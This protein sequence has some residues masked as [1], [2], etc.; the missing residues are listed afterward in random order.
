MDPDLLEERG[1]GIDL[2]DESRVALSFGPSP[3]PPLGRLSRRLSG[4]RRTASDRT[5]LA[6]RERTRPHLTVPNR[7][8]GQ[9]SAP[10]VTRV[11]RT[12][13]PFRRASGRSTMVS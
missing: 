13:R 7:T 4:V 6:T 8:E 2:D 3:T 9:Q 10:K 5:T 1:M 11:D 12:A